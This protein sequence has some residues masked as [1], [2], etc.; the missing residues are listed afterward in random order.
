MNALAPLANIL[1][2]AK[3]WP[4]SL[5]SDDLLYLGSRAKAFMFDW[6]K[7]SLLQEQ[8][9]PYSLSKN[10]LTSNLKRIFLMYSFMSQKLLKRPF[11]G[12]KALLLRGSCVVV[13]I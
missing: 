2:E 6:P 8:S 4:D 1:G 7:N 3:A 11:W 10:Q 9:D 13:N 12:M 5:Y